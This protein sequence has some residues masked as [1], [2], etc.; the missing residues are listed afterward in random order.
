[1]KLPMAI[2]FKF[3]GASRSQSIL[4]LIGISIAVATQIFIGLLIISLQQNLV[5]TSIGTTSH[6]T[7]TS[8]DQE[9]L[10]S[11]FDE[12]TDDEDISKVE[13][14]VQTNGLLDYDGDV[15]NIILTG[16]EENSDDVAQIFT[17]VDAP[18][19]DQI[20]LGETYMD[21]YQLGDEIELLDSNFNTHTFKVSGFVDYGNENSNQLLAYT[22]YD[23]LVNE[24]EINPSNY[25]VISQLADVFT[26]EEL[27]DEYSDNNISATNWQEQNESL[28]SGLSAQS[29]SS[30]MIQG[31]IIISV[32][33]SIASVLIISA[34]QKSSEVGILKAM[35]LNSKRA[36]QVFLYQGLILGIVG[37]IIGIGLGLVLLESFQTFV[38]DSYGNP[39]VPIVFNWNFVGISFIII[40]IA[41]FFASIVPARRI[42]KL[43]AVEVIS[44][45]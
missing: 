22:N 34:I 3:L 30:N 9:Q 11:L 38:L 21:E 15:N 18:S 35:G 4:I 1:M 24:W 19:T 37:A 14:Q 5:D 44:N 8:D 41:S 26:A 32:V 36:S 20:I 23:Y 17:Q 39:V 16:I 12:L 25:M 40:V 29:I 2:A 33:L 43:S 42:R 10:A 31:F 6:I 27:A 28:L 45:G 13:M 7:F